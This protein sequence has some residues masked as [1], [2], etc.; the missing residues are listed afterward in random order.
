[1]VILFLLGIDC[2]MIHP[3]SLE[4]MADLVDPVAVFVHHFLLQVQ[5]V[6]LAGL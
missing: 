2:E 6:Y 1:M 4:H 5:M 3:R